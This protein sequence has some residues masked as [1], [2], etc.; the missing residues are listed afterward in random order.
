MQIARRA[1]GEEGRL[2]MRRMGNGRRRS[3]AQ[4]RAREARAG[5]GPARLLRAVRHRVRYVRTALAGLLAAAAIAAFALVLAF[6]GPGRGTAG[7]AAVGGAGPQ[8]LALAS[9]S[10]TA[11]QQAARAS[12]LYQDVFN[13]PQTRAGQALRAGMLGTP[14]LAHA[15]R[16][17]PGMP[18]VWVIPVESASAPGVNLEP[19]MNLTSSRRNA[20]E[21]PIMGARTRCSTA[22]S[23]YRAVSQTEPLPVSC[24]ILQGF[25]GFDIKSLTGSSLSDQ[26]SKAATDLCSALYQ[27]HG[28][29]Q[30]GALDLLK[31]RVRCDAKGGAGK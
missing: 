23:C 9:T 20:E 14:V 28:M 25:S 19:V 15:Y 29:A 2:T 16:A 24:T 4:R 18:D 12:R 31:G 17:T 11:I 7:N 26:P 5:G 30:R 22:N 21:C 13:S 1:A 8:W 27:K 6:V 3:R 10:P